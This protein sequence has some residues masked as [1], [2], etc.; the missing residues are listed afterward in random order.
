MK[1]LSIKIIISMMFIAALSACSFKQDSPQQSKPQTQTELKKSNRP[2]TPLPPFPY[3]TEEV[4]I[5]NEKGG[6]ALAGTLII[7]KNTDNSTPIVIMVSGSGQQNRDEEVFEHKPFAVIADYLA[8]NGIASFRYD[9]RGVGKSTGDIL[10]ATTADFANDAEAVMN[11]IREN[12]QF[13]KVGILG[14]SEGGLIAY[15]LGAGNDTPDFIVSI[16]GPAVQGKEII[17]WQ[18]KVALKNSGFSE[19]DA[20]KFR[21]ALTKV[22]EYKLKNPDSTSINQELIDEFYSDSKINPLN[23]KLVASLKS[24]MKSKADNCWMI[25]FLGYNPADD[26]KSL[27]IPAFIIY[28]EKDQQVPPELNY[29]LATKL[30]P[31]AKVIIYPGLNHLMQHAITGRVEEYK[32]IEETF[33][34]EVLDDITSFI[35][36]VK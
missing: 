5:K 29:D 14:Y 20:E 13:G 19:P 15:M 18:N 8:R 23:A 21:N 22:F 30:A 1:D 24:V 6:T 16:A 11:W 17:A 9:K 33:A 10:N 2:Q 26:L 36:S 27:K 32:I 3:K 12:K 28:G 7:P 4:V 25:Y 35:K 31:K 34:P